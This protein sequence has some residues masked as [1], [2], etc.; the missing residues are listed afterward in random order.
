MLNMVNL[1]VH[2]F[3]LQGFIQAVIGPTLPELTLK[4][5]STYDHIS[6]AIG[7]KGK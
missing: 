6:Y 5:H 2:L 1:H 4:F 7:A 3:S